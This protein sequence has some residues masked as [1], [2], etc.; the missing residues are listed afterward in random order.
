VIVYHKRIRTPMGGG[1]AA[2]KTREEAEAFVEERRLRG[3]RFLTW[4]EL[5][6]EGKEHPWVPPV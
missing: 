6:E 5:L 4:K 1:L 3:A 2:F